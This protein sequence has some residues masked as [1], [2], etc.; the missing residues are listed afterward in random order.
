[1]TLL[2]ATFWNWKSV[3]GVGGKGGGKLL[4]RDGAE[5]I[6]SVCNTVPSLVVCRGGKGGEQKKKKKGRTLYEF[7]KGADNVDEKN[8]EVKNYVGKLTGIAKDNNLAKGPREYENTS[9]KKKLILKGGVI[10]SYAGQRGVCKT[11]GK[12][13]TRA[14]QN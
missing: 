1:M 13:G 9:E 2:Q 10:C 4:K 8:D 6:S 12:R 5:A 11:P 7:S 14:F 3:T